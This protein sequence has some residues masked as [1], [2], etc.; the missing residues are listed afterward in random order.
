MDGSG[1]KDTGQKDTGQ[2]SKKDP[3][4]DE[5]V[6][7]MEVDAGASRKRCRG[8]QD[9]LDWDESDDDE[10]FTPF[11]QSNPVIIESEPEEVFAKK[12]AP[13][14]MCGRK[15]SSAKKSSAK[16]SSEISFGDKSSSDKPSSDK[17]STAKSSAKRSSSKNVRD[18]KN[19]K[20]GKM[21]GMLKICTLSNVIA[22]DSI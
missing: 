14:K 3:G 10:V 11:T 1:Q 15:K 2:S 6:Q 8:P 17:P 5:S 16:K 13:K 4:E 20:K 18:V 22:F 21:L 12:S 9:C 19:S 7:G